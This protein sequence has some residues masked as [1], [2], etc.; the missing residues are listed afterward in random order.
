MAPPGEPARPS[1]VRLS[2]ILLWIGATS[3]GGSTP[4]YFYQE[5][6]RRR[7]WIS[8][9]DFAEAY[10]VGRLLPGPTGANTL[11]YLIQIVRGPVAAAYCLLPYALPSVLIMLALTLV[12]TGPLR[13]PLINGALTGAAM[14]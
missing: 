5:F 12:L 13:N 10:A 1:L 2:L 8:T 6:V 11:A 14:G 4:P 9:T 3:F 7:K